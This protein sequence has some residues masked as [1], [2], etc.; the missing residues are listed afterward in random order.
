VRASARGPAALAVGSAVTGVL[1]YV[2]FALVTRAIG[3]REAA[4]V[5]VLWTWWS[6]AAAGLTF[7][8][9]HWIVRSV[10]AAGT[11][12][13]G[14][15]AA[16][17]KVAGMVGGLSLLTAV[18]SWLL[19]EQLFHDG[20]VSF[21]VLV[22]VV[23]L[24][25]AFI[26]VVRGLLTAR[27]RLVAVGWALVAENGLRCLLAGGLL[28]A[29][30]EDALGYAVALAAGQ[31][32]GLL[33]PRAAMARGPA[34]PEAWFC[35]LGGAAAGQLI[36]QAVL[37]GGP[38]ALT[39]MGGRAAEVTALFAA[40]ALFRLP[41]TLA[42]GAVPPL[43]GV[44]TRMGAQGRIRQLR[45]AF[46]GI[47]AGTLVAAL[48]AAVVAQL[49]G[50]WLLRLV[51]GSTV[52]LTGEVCALVAAGS[53][54]AL[55]CLLLSLMAMARERSVLLLRAWGIGA[56]TAAVVLALGPG[57]P[58]TSVAMAFVAAEAVAAVVL[59]LM[60]G[61]TLNRTADTGLGETSR[62]P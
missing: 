9:Q 53:A 51:F 56:A 58:L 60:V 20:G 52:R 36:G 48:L 5:S 30:A 16:L 13:G 6:F 42:L 8:L 57:A 11:S 43:T 27:D 47:L 21:P 59:A 22:G 41:Y 55:G 29:G 15:R 61:R 40:L 25:S 50:P 10:A 37:T 12:E 23:T 4:G 1:A 7:P 17:P 62:T 19:R 18:L 33:W 31:L 34:R 24:G 44:F 32:V 54:F 28:L 2:F 14:V 26:G 35:F 45:R 38:V 39:L 46:G 49:V 3:A